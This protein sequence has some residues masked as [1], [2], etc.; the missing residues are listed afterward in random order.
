MRPVSK[1][2]CITAFYLFL[3]AGIS[4]AEGQGTG[5]NSDII[6]G[7]K[8]GY[9]MFEGYYK[10]R[11]SGSYCLGIS[12]M[13]SNPA[14]VK[15]LMGE[16]ELAFSK[17]KVNESSNSYFFILSG[18][19]GPLF[20]YPVHPHVQIYTGVSA[21]GSYLFL[22]ASRSRKNTSS[23]KPGLLAK[24]GFFFPVQMGF[25]IRAGA[26]YSLHYLSGKPLHGLNF[27]GGVSYNFNPAERISTPEVIGGDRGENIE[28]YLILGNRA[29]Q[30]GHVDEAKANFS[31][32]LA[33]D[34]SNKEAL[35]K[36]DAISSAETEF[37]QARKFIEDKQYFDALP[38]LESAGRYLI[39]ARK[40]RER[41]RAE[42]AGEIA[43]LEKR[44]ILLYER[45]DY[46]GCISIMKNLLL[47]DPHNR[48]AAIYLPRA[49]K[50]QEAL[51]RLR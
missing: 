26:E 11:F 6:L 33:L 32:A 48:T 12:T 5:S 2:I 39:S 24:A 34:R 29:L 15:Y 10:N 41:L 27:I 20:N 23:F 7:V 50:R 38:L 36:L 4:F 46:R 8:G 1:K 40:E 13:Y 43:V 9:S 16:L 42:L 28:L 3:S 21:Q 22:H 49:V 44:G 18:N 30:R 31:K 45:G 14:I 35:E 17:Y 19:L 37:G 47:V 25:R 51:E